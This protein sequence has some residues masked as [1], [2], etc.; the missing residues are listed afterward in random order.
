MTQF[1][2]RHGPALTADENDRVMIGVRGDSGHL[3]REEDCSRC[4][5]AGWFDVPGYPEGGVCFKCRGR[6]SL[7]HTLRVYSAEKLAVLVNAADKRTAKNIAVATSKRELARREF[8]TWAR[9]HGRLIGGILTAENNKFLAG[10]AT[11]LRQRWTLSEK[12]L[13]AAQRILGQQAER[14]AAD[15]ASDHVGTIRTRIEFEAHVIGVY[16]SE[17]FYGHTDIVKFRDAD[18]NLFVWFASGYTGLER[19]NRISI[20]GT[21][22]EHDEFRGVKQTVLTRCKFEK[23]TVM[24]PDEAAQAEVL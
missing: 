3:T 8:I 20:K 2:F 11:K 23:F 13:D 15:A 24:T 21:I 7:P 19:E 10:L 17:G 12:Q 6:R 5:G 16:G 14:M 1:F 18:G 9:P 22:K 4:G